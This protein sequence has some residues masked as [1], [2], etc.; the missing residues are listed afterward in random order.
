MLSKNDSPALGISCSYIT[1]LLSICIT[2]RKNVQVAEMCFME[3]KDDIIFCILTFFSCWTLVSFFVCHADCFNLLWYR[4]ANIWSK[5]TSI[6]RFTS[7]Q[8][9]A[10]ILLM[11][12]CLNLVI[13]ISALTL[14]STKF[15]DQTLG[16]LSGA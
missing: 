5:H 16:S 11:L 6:Y 13:L 12:M 7:L 1:T 9:W 14:E 10:Q 8:M 15:S 4:F 2:W 3:Y